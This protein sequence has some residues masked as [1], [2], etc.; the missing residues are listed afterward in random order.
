MTV[1]RG[2]EGSSKGG[3]PSELR[4]W[5]LMA[6]DF[7]MEISERGKVGKLGT[8]PWTSWIGMPPCERTEVLGGNLGP[9]RWFSQQG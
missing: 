1:N 5:I 2:G 4:Q 8:Q 7:L 6:M 3:L 9:Q